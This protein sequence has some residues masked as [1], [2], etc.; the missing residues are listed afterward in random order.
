MTIRRLPGFAV[1]WLALACGGR[2]APQTVPPPEVLLEQARREF[3]H[4]GFGKALEMFQR[5]TFDLPP[6]HPARAEVAYYVGE[7]H[8]QRGD[9]VQA[10]AEFRKASDQYPNSPYAALA[11]LRAGDA[12]LRMWNSPELDPT[13]GFNALAVYQELAGRYPGTEAAERAQ[14]HVRQL[15]EWFSDKAYRNGLFYLSRKAYDSA[16]IYFKD[17]VA[18]YPET[19]RAADALLRLV[20]TYRSLRYTEEVQETCAH[21][22]RYY[23]QAPGVAEQCPAQPGTG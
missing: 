6:G 8:F 20:D 9:R 16:I 14:L 1:L 13:P 10:A 17:V 12:H 22:W 4:G 19:P 7:S 18:T 11:L 5:L 23:A 3:R 15:R 21:L 2:S